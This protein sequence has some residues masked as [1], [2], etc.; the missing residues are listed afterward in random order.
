MTSAWI[1]YGAF[2]C[3]PFVRWQGSLAHLHSVKFAAHAAKRELARR[4]IAPDVFDLS[5]LGTTVPQ[6]HAFYGV[7]W[8]LGMMGA[9]NAGGPTIS[10]ACATSVRCL[11]TAAQAVADGSGTTVLVVAADRTSN[12]PHLYYPAPQGSGGVGDTENWVPDNFGLDPLIG[13]SMVETAENVARKHGIST[14]EQHDLVLQRYAQYRDTSPDFFARFMTLPYEVPDARFAKTS[15][16]LAGDEGI[17]ES[18]AEGLARLKPVLAGG[19]VTY[20]AQTHPADGHAA[21]VVTTRAKAR[22]LSARPEIGI[23]LAGFGAARVAPGHM[24]EAPVPAARAALEQAGIGIEQ[25]AAITSHNPFALNDIV[26]ARATGAGLSAM[27]AHGCSLIWGHPQA[28]TGLRS[29]IELI[30][31]LVARG[32]GW[33]LFHGCAAG[34]T[35]MAAVIEV[36]EA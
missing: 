26:F 11:Q 30:E 34:D 35:A 15:A 25:L 13:K 33:G 31:T 16:T 14:S 7:P 28:P 21:A 1:P 27:N 23:R 8:L 29:I 10:Q 5:V 3:S 9:T 32:G 2:W 12:S 19:T 17:I 24:P 18:T 36:R 20:G 4:S 22:E 6:R